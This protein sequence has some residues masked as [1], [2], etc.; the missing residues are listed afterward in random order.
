MGVAGDPVQS[1]AKIYRYSELIRSL[2]HLRQKN[3][4]LSDELN[5]IKNPKQ[6]SMIL[7]QLD[8]LYHKIETVVAQEKQLAQ[9]ALEDFHAVF[10]EAP[11]IE[12]LAALSG[13]I[14]SFFAQCNQS[15]QPYPNHLKEKFDEEPLEFAQRVQNI[16]ASV[17]S[18]TGITD[19]VALLQAFSQNPV[20]ALRGITSSLNELAALADKAKNQHQPLTGVQISVDTE[21]AQQATR[22][23]AAVLMVM[24]GWRAAE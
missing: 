17:H 20:G 16:Y 18:R 7:R 8:E 10:G 19:H 13:E 21:R 24:D 15:N 6:F 3:W 22:K 11:T 23:L 4:D 5:Q 12:N 14:A 9:K 2:E 1:S